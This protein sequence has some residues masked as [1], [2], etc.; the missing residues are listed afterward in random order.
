MYLNRSPETSEYKY[1]FL[2]VD[3]RIEVQNLFMVKNDFKP[4]NNILADKSGN[5]D[6]QSVDEIYWVHL[7]VTCYIL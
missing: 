5:N 3:G 6:S 1:C 4:A 7:K 2:N